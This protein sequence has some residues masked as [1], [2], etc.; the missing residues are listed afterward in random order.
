MSDIDARMADATEQPALP[1][2]RRTIA[3]L[4]EFALIE[5]ISA[6]LPP[7]SGPLLVGPGDDAA[8]LAVPDGRVVATTDLLVE[9]RH[10]RRAWSGPADIGARAAAQSLADIAAM[11]AVPSAL[12]VGFAGPGSLEVRWVLD[13]VRGLAAEAKRAGAGVAGGDLSSGDQIVLAF[14]A[15][16]DLQDRPP[17]LRSGAHPGEVVALA[18]SV[19]ASAA[20][21]ALLW[22]GGSATGSSRRSPTPRVPSAGSR[23][24]PSPRGSEQRDAADRVLTDQ[25]VR[26]YRR[27]RPPYALGPAAARHGAT[28]MIDISDGL[29]QDLGHVAIA[30][31]VRID[32][33]TRRL[34]GTRRLARAAAW[35]GRD[36]RDWALT[37]GE[38]HALAATFPRGAAL[39][40][41]WTIIGSV[42]E[43]SGVTVD[44]VRWQ[45]AGGWEHYR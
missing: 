16:G 42:S 10:F 27:P 31:Q 8:V 30:S 17:V 15:L 2:H 11:G 18:G 29:V 4:G 34:P 36:W 14:T 43:G 3:E 5:A 21:L 44:S 7:V 19:G 45:R 20:G 6:V 23:G 35:L 26:A 32:V 39:P 41:G 40:R 25:L 12:L 24:A 38:D 22:A 33:A 28:S 37:G 13:L 1:G 9:D